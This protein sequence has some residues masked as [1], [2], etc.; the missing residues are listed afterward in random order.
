MVGLTHFLFLMKECEKIGVL[1][2]FYAGFC[3]VEK[4]ADF[5]GMEKLFSQQ[6]KPASFRQHRRREIFVASKLILTMSRSDNGD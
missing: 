3:P 5:R 2:N 6:G 4:D 1:T